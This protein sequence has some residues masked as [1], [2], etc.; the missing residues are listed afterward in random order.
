MNDP[1]PFGTYVPS[2]AAQWVIDRTQA[3]PDTWL[4]RRLHTM[5]RH[6]GIPLLNGAPIDVERLGVRMRLHPYTN[7][8][9]KKVLFAPQFFDPEERAILK[10]RLRDGFTFIDVGANIGAY[11]LFA[12]AEAG[13]TAHILA[14]EPQPVVF[15]RL[16]YNIR[17]NPFGTIKAVACAVADKPG[18]LTLFIDARNSGES[19]VKIVGSSQ[20]QT[21]R[22]PAATLLQLVTQESFPRV[23]A[24][25]LD[26]EGA[27]DIILEP[28]FRDAPPALYPSLII[29][30]RGGGQWQIDLPKLLDSKGYRLRLKTRLNLVF[31]RD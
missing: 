19:S 2:K 22:V 9:D 21:L 28:Y 11:A 29:L 24:V 26:V 4:G 30:E 20:S 13:P 5:L 6:V 18:E 25:K 7:I 27:E 23:D 10:S 1:A 8:C 12:A 14:V 31:D 16:V 15:D 17:Q 3:L